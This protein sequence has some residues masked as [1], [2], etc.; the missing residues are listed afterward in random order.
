MSEAKADAKKFISFQSL[1]NTI[2]TKLTVWFL[3]LS[4]APLAILFVFVWGNVDQQ[5]IDM[6]TQHM[7][8]QTK[9]LGTGVSLLNDTDSIRTLFIQNDSKKFESFLISVNETNTAYFGGE[10]EFDAIYNRFSAEI[11]R[12]IS[13]KNDGV[14]VDENKKWAVA[15]CKVPGKDFVVITFVDLSYALLPLTRIEGIGFTQIGATL[16]VAAVVIG[17]VIFLTMKPIR[18]LVKVTEK[19]RT[20]NLDIQINPSKFEGEMETLAIGF[21]QMVQNLKIYQDQVKRHAEELEKQVAE[22]TEEMEKAKKKLESKVDELEKFSKLS[23]GRELKM[24]ELKKRISELE[25]QLK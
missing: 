24:V 16:F 12:Q 25:N 1:K 14:F 23:V 7:H 18:D 4:L 15:F 9:L 22:R 20:G 3:L 17:M 6:T 13:A 10:R 19:V 2:A 8:E 11:I 5:F 21:D